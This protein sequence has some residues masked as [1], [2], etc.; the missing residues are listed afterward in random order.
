M[1]WLDRLLGRCCRPSALDQHNARRISL[2][3]EMRA[4]KFALDKETP[5]ETVEFYRDVAAELRRQR[6]E[7]DV[8][9]V[10]YRV[11][12]DLGG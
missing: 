9:Y 4:L 6:D 11:K 5:M 3:A 8:R 7:A 10:N 2:D 12:G 1:R